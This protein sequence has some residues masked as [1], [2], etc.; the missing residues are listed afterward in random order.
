MD[1]QT[2]IHAYSYYRDNAKIQN[3]ALFKWITKN[4]PLKGFYLSA[5]FLDSGLLFNCFKVNQVFLRILF[6]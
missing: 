4:L 2:Y 3:V 5:K 6:I 1:G